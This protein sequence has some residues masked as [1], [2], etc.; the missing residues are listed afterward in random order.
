[1]AYFRALVVNFIFG[2]RNSGQEGTKRELGLIVRC[3]E[4]I[5]IHS[6]VVACWIK[7]GHLRAQLRGTKRTQQQRGDTY[8]IRGKGVRHFILE[9]PTEIDLR[10]VD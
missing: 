5:G 3:S 7:G 9:H 8:L 10:K 6:H 2:G 1:V 4:Q